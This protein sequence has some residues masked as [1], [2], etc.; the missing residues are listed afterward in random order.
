MR[1]RWALQW[2]VVQVR[3]L[4]AFMTLYKDHTPHLAPGN[5]HTW[6]VTDSQLLASS[7]LLSVGLDHIIQ[8]QSSCA[9]TISHLP[10]FSQITSRPICTEQGGHVR[11]RQEGREQRELGRGPAIHAPSIPARMRTA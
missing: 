9:V 4:R 1:L 11:A 2:W 3:E 6:Y 5:P 7:P 10:F 8:G